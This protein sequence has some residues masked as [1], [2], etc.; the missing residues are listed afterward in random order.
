[1]RGRSGK[2]KQ[3]QT[4][5]NEPAISVHASQ[6]A[7]IGPAIVSQVERKPKLPTLLKAAAN[8]IV[9]GASPAVIA[10]A[11]T[12]NKQEF[13]SKGFKHSAMVLRSLIETSEDPEGVIEVYFNTDLVGSENMQDYL[14][15]K[16]HLPF[17]RTIISGAIANIRLKDLT[18][19]HEERKKELTGIDRAN[20]ILTN[21]TTL[22]ESLAELCEFLPHAFQHA[23]HAQARIVYNGESYTSKRFKESQWSL[24][25]TFETPDQRQGSVEIFYTRQFPDADDGPFLNE[26]CNFLKNLSSLILGTISQ[27]ALKDLLFENT[28]RLKELKGINSTYEIL[29]RS[30]KLEDSLPQICAI[31]PAS[32][33]YPEDT[34]VRI[35][36]GGNSY[37][38]VGFKETPW[39][40]KQFFQTDT[41]KKGSIEVFYTRQFP[42]LDEGPFLKEE[43]NLLNNLAELI[44]GRAVKN[45]FTRLHRVNT[46]RQKELQ[47]INQTSKIIEES[48]SV[49]E[50]L[51][52]ICNIL[53]QSWQYPKFTAC[54][55]RFER[56]EYITSNFDET[57]WVQQE[58]L[59]TI[60]NK[61]GSIE[62]FYL[63][64]F[65]DEQEGP[66]L[67]EERDLIRNI[68][69]LVSGYLNSHKGLEII[70]NKGV[71]ISSQHRSDE[72]RKSLVRTKK[73]LQLYFNQQSLE[74]YVYLDMMKYKVKHI[75]FVST[76]Y[77]AFMLESED[78]FF[79]KFLGEI[80]QYSLFSLP[81]ITGVSSAEEALELLETTNFDLVILMAG[82]DR[83]APIDLS[84]QI[85]D[86]NKSIP[87]YLLLN[88]K[89]DL[90]YFEGLLPTI[91]SVD[92][93]FVWNGDS[94]ILFAIVKSIE[95]RVNVENDTR[96]GLV[97]VILVIEDSP[98]YYSK[99]LQFLY[100]IVFDQVQQILPE[101]EKNELDKIGRMRSRPKILLAKNYEE[102]TAIFNKYKDF[103]LCV[104][105]DM[106][107]ERAGRMDKKAGVSF[108]Q[109]AKA[110]IHKLPVVLQSSEVSNRNYAKKLDAVFLDKNSETLL[111]DLKHFLK[112]YLGFGNFVFLN[113]KDE[114][115][116]VAKS[117][118]EFETLLQK[119]PDESF[120]LHA[121]ENNF[122]LWL[123]ARGEIQL[124]R[125]LNPVPV[126]SIE[127]VGESRKF[128]LETI[129]RYRE[130]KKKGRIMGFDETATLDERNI[131]SF[132][133]GSLGGKGRGL[134]FIN[135]LI[136]N[137]DFSALASQI[138]I[139]TPITVIVG[140]NEFQ[141]FINRNNLIEVVTDPDISYSELRKRFFEAE[142]S[143]S[144]MRK[145]KIL[146]NQIDKP[147]AVRSSS[148]S[149]DSITHPFSGVF[150][151]YI[152]PNSKQNKRKVAEHLSNAIKMVYASIYSDGARTYF[153]AIQHRVEDEKMAIVLQE[154]VGSYH[155]DHYYPHISGVAQS[156]NYYPVADMKPEEGFAVIA[157]GL[158][159]YVVGGWKSYR[160]SPTY[161][162]VSVYGIKDLLNSTQVKFY[163]LNCTNL[164]LDLLNK[165]ELASLDLLD[166]EE[167]EKHG[168]LKHCASVYNPDNDR[169]EPG[170]DTYGPRVVNFA[171][172]LQYEYIPLAKTI[173]AILNAVEE[174]FG[175]PV[176]IEFAV[177]LTPG[178]HGLPTFYLLQIKP[179]L[180]SLESHYFDFNA[181]DPEKML[182]R[183]GMSL[184]NGEINKITDVI[185]VA[186]DKFNKMKTMEMA[187]EIESLNN[188]M[189]KEKRKYILIGPGR[190]GTRDQFLGIP[191]NWAQ[192]SNAKVIVETS[193][194]NFPLDSSLGSHFFHNVTSMNIGYF[195]VLHHSST[196]VIRW[197]LLN[198]Q[199][200]VSETNYFKHVRFK[201]PLRVVMNGKTKTSA[202]IL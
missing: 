109:Y 120:Y 179:L 80:Y 104:I 180:A 100:S 3:E 112:N 183:S 153:E 132:C 56:R 82:L 18:H 134:A 40:I 35:N 54:R 161:P 50:A 78:S 103:I 69:K 43:R 169:I 177:D 44:A 126:N 63:K 182:L 65:P 2:N 60:D 86:K 167:A 150:D 67:R 202:I 138:N 166:I 143:S 187:A 140:T 176:E 89:S 137:Y 171:N 30:R 52:R 96:V 64:Q 168:T 27:Y 68:S 128:F 135:V 98:L 163:G 93:L 70:N 29:K 201:N 72:F 189:V 123:M 148:T 105:S 102:A 136:Y 24:R 12:Y 58:G 26:E 165:G 151:T 118:R 113:A 197:D 7:A 75:L 81:R 85:R 99:Y 181:I 157:I 59:M 194:E 184:G 36:Y 6:L 57:P 198:E 17:W 106:E 116:A 114:K 156:Y 129:N 107:F 46:E 191:V 61:K 42:E 130:E 94:L 15:V 170:L 5:G 174:A 110:N 125:T 199:T 33:Q 145:L 142:L 185:F 34:V 95:D 160:F 1:M 13:L 152:I 133:A 190:W 159:T 144:L 22:S 88:K 87:I 162:K 84:E 141:N 121:L 39:M 25:R 74:K 108:I 90:K 193:L 28:E 172:I 16:E 124:A 37:K 10:V 192:I 195:S 48:N 79:E 45:M 11:I 122:S 155:G 21:S 173:D 9:E 147:I 127:N 32:F 73:P 53:P 19:R 196:D 131:V 23:K 186:P 139:S 47:A 146:A 66:F 91:H 117:L 8:K 115:I 92:Q 55:I 76:L 71:V 51:Q 101:V 178:K 4:A 49:D 158:G 154:L 175:S 20:E 14:A 164:D 38:S 97:R 77:D 149:E 188:K 200:L 111:Q 83:K 119:I 62:V 31:I 41:T